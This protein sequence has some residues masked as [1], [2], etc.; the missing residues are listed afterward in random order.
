[1]KKVT[2]ILAAAFVMLFAG[3][4]QA[5][6]GVNF[7]FAPQTT[8]TTVGSSNSSASTNGYFVGVNYNKVLTGTIGLSVGVQGR[9]NY[10]SETTTV[11]SVS[12]TTKQTQFIVDVPVLFNFGL[13]LSDNAHISIFAGPTFSYALSGNTNV[14]ENVLNTSTD[15]PWYGDNSNSNQLDILGTVGATFAYQSFRIFGGY[16]LGLLDL[17]KRD[18]VKTTTNGIFVGLG[19]VL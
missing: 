9:Y 7:G 1:M 13:I 4:A 12:T 5:Q 17:D 15:H 10:K 18:N 14:S 11:L 8:T 19:Y 16:R 6:L 2:L 3:N